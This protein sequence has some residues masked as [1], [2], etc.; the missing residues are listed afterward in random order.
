M[1]DSRAYVY[2]GIKI[3]Q[4]TEDH[5][6]VAELVRSGQITAEEA[7]HHPRK[8]VVLRA[9]GTDPDVSVD[10]FILQSDLINVLIV[11]SDGLSNKLKAS[12]VQAEIERGVKLSEVAESLIAQ[13]NDRGGEDNITIALVRFN[14][15]ISESL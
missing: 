10:V 14:E 6:L 5:S 7:E 9:L 13:A 2:N 3:S 15:E 12:E 8:N 1:G 11:C 4:Q